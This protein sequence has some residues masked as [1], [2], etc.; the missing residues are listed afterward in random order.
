[1]RYIKIMENFHVYIGIIPSYI[2]LYLSF[3]PF[4]CYA[5]DLFVLKDKG[6]V[7][8]IVAPP[9]PL[10]FQLMNIHPTLKIE[11]IRI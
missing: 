11:T 1:M 9:P 2:K 8:N 4:A 3:F 5:H 10:I 6:E 7:A